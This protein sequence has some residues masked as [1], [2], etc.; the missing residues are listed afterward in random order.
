MSDTIQKKKYREI[1]NLTV[2]NLNKSKSKSKLT[3]E[4]SRNISI[5]PLSKAFFQLGQ[6]RSHIPLNF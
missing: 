1:K 3:Q 5:F 6:N 4:N 2:Y